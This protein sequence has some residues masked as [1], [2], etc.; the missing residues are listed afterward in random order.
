MI[1]FNMK[2]SDKKRIILVSLF[3]LGI[4]FFS[5]NNAQAQDLHFSQ[6]YNSPLN[7]NP[8]LTGVFNGD[9]RVVGSYRNQWASV[10]VPWTTYSVAYDQ[11]IYLKNFDRFYLNAGGLINYDRQGDSNIALTNV[12]GLLSCS[13]ITNPSTIITIGVLAGYSTRAFDDTSL[14]WDSQWNGESFDPS[15]PGELFNP[16]MIGFFE[17]GAGINIRFQKSSRTKLDI[18]GGAYHLVQPEVAFLSSD[19]IALPRRYSGTLESS[20]L[21]SNNLDGIANGL[22]QRQ[23]DYQEILVS[24]LLKYYLSRSRG[25]EINLYA[26]AG[27]RLSGSIFPTFA[28]DYNQFY[29]SFSYDIDISDAVAKT[30]GRGG[31]ELHFRYNFK[32]VKPLSQ[33]KVCP[34]Y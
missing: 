9:K 20:I 11:K 22:Y 15:L 21:L 8:G 30:N 12:N 1:I 2:L 32:S 26:G 31:P 34:I 3:T 24:G 23:E 14:R 28:I 33:F 25:K 13:H 10:P 17:T 29:F 4:I 7:V 6:F 16:Q 18:G 27:Y 19:N 5:K